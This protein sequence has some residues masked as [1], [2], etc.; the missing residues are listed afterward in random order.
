ME[1]ASG[2]VTHL[3]RLSDL[4]RRAVAARLLA[5]P[6]Q[7]VHDMVLLFYLFDCR[8]LMIERLAS[9][10]AFDFCFLHSPNL[11]RLDTI[12]SMIVATLGAVLYHAKYSFFLTRPFSQKL[13]SVY[14]ARD[15]ST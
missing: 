8:Q 3:E 15:L 2:R 9:L 5:T 10:E 4:R 11:C 12:L 7:K 13:S 1:D 14:G 6:G